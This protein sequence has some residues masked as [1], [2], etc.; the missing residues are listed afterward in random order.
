MTA[1]S[2]LTVPPSVTT[3]NDSALM[4][5]RASV[6][7]VPGSERLNPWEPLMVVSDTVLPPLL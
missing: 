2:M 5:T 6:S 4:L 1:S 7:T 3:P